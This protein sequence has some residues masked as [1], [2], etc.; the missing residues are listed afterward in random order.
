MIKGFKCFNKDLTNRYGFKFEV[1]KTYKID[2]EPKFGNNGNGFHMCKNLEDTLR[3]FD[4]TNN[5]VTICE[6]EGR[7]KYIKYNDEY[8]GYYDMYA[9]S[10]IKI[11]KALTHDEIISYAL[12]LPP[13]RAQRFI[14]F[15]NLSKEELKMF[16]E[17]FIKEKEVINAIS[18]YKENIKDVYSRKL[19]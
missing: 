10:E 14:Q 19:R 8:N 11:V 1:G 7:S 18:Y 4:L 3:Y 5:N 9:V 2:S 17:K 6:V 12:N 13:N 15:F 16:K